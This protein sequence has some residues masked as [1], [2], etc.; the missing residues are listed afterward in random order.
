MRRA[1]FRCAESFR[2][3][4]KPHRSIEEY[5]RST[6]DWLFRAQA[7]TSDGGVAESYN[8][9]SRSWNPSYPETT[10]Y[11][12]CSLLRAESLHLKEPE[13]LRDAVVKMGDWLL[14]TQMEC[15]AFPGGHIGI[16]RKHPTVFNTGQI[17]KGLTDLIDRGLDRDGQFAGCAARAAHWLREVQEPT[18]EWRRGRSPL[19][20]GTVHSYDIRTAWALARYG[21]CV[22]D[23]AAI[24]AGIRNAAW[25]C[26]LADA[27]AWFP[28]MSFRPDDAPLTHTVAYTVQ[29][30]LEIGFLAGRSEFEEIAMAAASRMKDLQDPHTGALP[31]RIAPGYRRASS[32]SSTT[33]NAQMS[34]IWF[35]LAEVTGD[36]SWRKS[37]LHSNLFN[38][39]LQELD[40]DH[41]DD[42]R[43]GGLRGSFPGHL[44]YGRYWYMNWTHKFHLDA[45]LAQMGM[46]IH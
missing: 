1:G 28:H 21:R 35:R 42:G 14:S 27:A 45:L 7:A 34:I 12:V 19:T 38:C 15:G 17:L 41:P 20:Q 3:R 30:L 39:S 6:I 25:L 5:A 11:I 23:D 9:V 2:G 31:G 44:G 40:M 33:G 4:G 46:S 32:W 8:V 26:S 10:G 18:G 13:I 22:S 16:A 37:A 24:L 29:G 36:E 43:R